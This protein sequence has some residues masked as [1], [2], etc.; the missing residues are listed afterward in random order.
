MTSLKK[1]SDHNYLWQSHSYLQVVEAALLRK[2]AL[3][4]IPT[5]KHS[6]SLLSLRKRRY[7]RIDFS[8]VRYVVVNIQYFFN[9][10]G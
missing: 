6:K 1:A 4:P 9:S 10:M 7:S 8:A 3:G 5:G 2:P